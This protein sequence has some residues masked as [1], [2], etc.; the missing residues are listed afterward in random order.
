VGQPKSA[1]I[2]AFLFAMFW[3][4]FVTYYVLWKSYQR[5]VFMR[6]RAQANAFARPQQYTVLVRDIP[7]PVG[8]E[9]RSQLVD[10]FFSRVHPGAYNRVLPTHDTKPVSPTIRTQ[11]P[12]HVFL[13]SHSCS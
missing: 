13:V 10:S 11:I 5:V 7:K 9:S 12:L 2:W 4:S 1:K 6:D 8:K 3:V